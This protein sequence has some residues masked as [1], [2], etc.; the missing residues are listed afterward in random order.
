MQLAV[1]KSLC[2]DTNSE[3]KEPSAFKGV[4]HH[5]NV[6]DDIYNTERALHMNESLA[7]SRGG[8]AEILFPC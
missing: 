6:K 5:N 3:V 2:T 7:S 8:D 4:P 1:K